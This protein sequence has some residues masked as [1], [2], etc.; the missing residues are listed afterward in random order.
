[1]RQH[2]A[3]TGLEPEAIPNRYKGAWAHSNSWD[4][5]RVQHCCL[6]CFNTHTHIYI[7]VCS[8]HDIIWLVVSTPLKNMKVSWDD[9]IPRWKSHKSHVPNHQPVMLYWEWWFSI[10]WFSICQQIEDMWIFGAHGSW[11]QVAAVPA[12]WISTVTHPMAFPRDLSMISPHLL[13]KSH[14]S[15]CLSYGN[16]YFN[17]T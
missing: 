12:K 10:L 17:D 6:D 4:I 8:Y 9:E 5:N 16:G 3:S 7:Y 13:L 2:S 1:M 15:W 14:V 11:P